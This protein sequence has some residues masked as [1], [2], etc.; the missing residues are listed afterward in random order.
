MCV[1]NNKLVVQYNGGGLRFIFGNVVFF[2][3]KCVFGMCT[4][5]S[6]RRFAVVGFHVGVERWGWGEGGVLSLEVISTTDKGSPGAD[7]ADRL[8]RPSS[9]DTPRAM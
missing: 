1:A 6:S 9:L 8:R 2:Y 7:S 5:M 4:M 3:C